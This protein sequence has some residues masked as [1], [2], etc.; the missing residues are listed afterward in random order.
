MDAITP[1]EARAY[2]RRWQLLREE[3]A[4]QL[5]RTPMETKLRQLAAL[6]ASR[7]LFG[8]EPDREAGVEAV[9]ERWARLRQAVSG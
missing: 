1:Q 8:V 4:R 9:R 2:F 6:M 5:A 3:E 7:H